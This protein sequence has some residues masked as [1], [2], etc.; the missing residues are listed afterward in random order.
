MPTNRSFDK[1]D[2]SRSFS[3]ASTSYD[4]FASLQRTI[5]E[6]L[7]AQTILSNHPFGTILD[8]GSGTGFLTSKLRET[9]TDNN[10]IALDIA[11]AMLIKAKQNQISDVDFVCADAEKLPL[12]NESIASIFSNLAF[13]W[14]TNLPAVFSESYRVMKT[15]GVLVFS[16]FGPT[17]LC[18]LND[19][20]SSADGSVHVNSFTSAEKITAY[21]GAAG[22]I[23]SHVHYQTI[24]F[25]YPSAI[26]LMRDLKGMGAHNINS[27]RKKGLTGKDAF[28]RMLEKYEQYRVEEG[29]P[30][31]FQAVYGFAR[32][33]AAF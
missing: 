11:D 23:D 28:K 6:K 25:H 14:S 19:A 5:G 33:K 32:K 21:L 15:G 9:Y 27:Q 20:W 18:E 31:T 2:I 16:S 4:D 24:T 8:A 10:I 29:L 1:R 3:G 7:M 17:T 22:F 12:A 13:Q 30:A 26:E